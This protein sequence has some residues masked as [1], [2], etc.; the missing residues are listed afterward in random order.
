MAH[1]ANLRVRLTCP[2]F[3][4]NRN[5]SFA[6]HPMI[7]VAFSA[8]VSGAKFANAPWGRSPLQ[9]LSYSSILSCA[10]AND[11]NH[12]SF[13]HSA[14]SRV[15]GGLYDGVIGGLAWP[16][17]VQIHTLEISPPPLTVD[18]AIFRCRSAAPQRARDSRFLWCDA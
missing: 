2:Y 12:F 7:A 14:R 1:F 13:R 17:E 16:A 18:A 11:R 15:L 5:V 9:R 6:A 10:S 3:C 4:T 8:K